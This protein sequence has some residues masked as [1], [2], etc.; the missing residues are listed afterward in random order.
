MK[1]DYKGIYLDPKTN[2][3]YVSTTFTSADKIKKQYVKR[4]FD[5][6]DDALI[7]KIKKAQEVENTYLENIKPKE[8]ASTSDLIERYSLY[9]AKHK[10]QSTI[11]NNKRVLT[12]I[13]KDY[14]ISKMKIDDFEKLHS[15]IV[16]SVNNPNTVNSY[17]SK[18]LTFLDYLTTIDAFDIRLYSKIKHL[19]VPLKKAE[20]KQTYLTMDQLKTFLN[21]FEEPLFQI[22]TKLLFFCGFRKGELYALRYC[23]IDPD[24]YATIDKQLLPKIYANTKDNNIQ[25]NTKTNVDKSVLIPS[26]L[27]QE[28]LDYQNENNIPDDYLICSNS[29]NKSIFYK[30]ESR[31]VKA[32]EMSGLDIRIHG[33]RHSMT[34]YM[35]DNGFDLEY[36]AKRL[37]HKTTSTTLNTYKHLTESKRQLN[38]NKVN[39]IKF[40]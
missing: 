14:N 3:Y 8:I 18:L 4:G 31:F 38:D 39:L 15:E 6:Q 17:F 11:Y 22:I 2:K 9:S 23:D 20:Y 27:Y 33:L 12:N 34:T 25:H 13:L 7:W 24:G 37:G 36:V 30:Y 10:K 28:L 19:F 35:L 40:E 1:N 21:A 16:E 29:D 32:R 26:W 5:T